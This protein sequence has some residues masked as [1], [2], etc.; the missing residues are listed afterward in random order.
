MEDI[1]QK[2]LDELKELRKEVK[3]LKE[4]CSKMDGHIDF[5]ESVYEGLKTPLNYISLRFNGISGLL[6]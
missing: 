3:E 1:N 4:I 6:E 2:I 5:V